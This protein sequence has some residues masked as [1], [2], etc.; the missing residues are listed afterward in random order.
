MLA[1]SSCRYG[2]LGRRGRARR[3]AEGIGSGPA[4]VVRSSAGRAHVAAITWRLHEHIAHA[5]AAIAAQQ[6]SVGRERGRQRR[7]T[8]DEGR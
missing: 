6:Q 1:H 4:D 8:V 2:R 7:T 3:G 5:V